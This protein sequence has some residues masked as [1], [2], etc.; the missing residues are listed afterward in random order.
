M[1]K[2]EKHNF[3][4]AFM[5]KQKQRPCN[6]VLYAVIVYREAINTTGVNC[7]ASAYTPN[8]HQLM[9]LSMKNNRN[10]V[11]STG[12]YY[13]YNIYM[14]FISIACLLFCVFLFHILWLFI[15]VLR[16]VCMPE[17]NQ[18]HVCYVIVVRV[19]VVGWHCFFFISGCLVVFTKFLGGESEQNM[20]FFGW[21]YSERVGISRLE[22]GNVINTCITNLSV[23]KETKIV[24]SISMIARYRGDNTKICPPN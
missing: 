22:S 21:W 23:K 10:C 15:I 12:R 20:A 9:N 1:N 5:E 14:M 6:F 4:V 8:Q 3:A 13:I 17:E 24:F 11:S 7:R 19:P 16:D 18:M 2:I